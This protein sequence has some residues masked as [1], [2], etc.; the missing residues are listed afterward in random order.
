MVGLHY[1]GHAFSQMEVYLAKP[2]VPMSMLRSNS[3]MSP[4]ETQ[5]YV[6]QAQ[7]LY[8]IVLAIPKP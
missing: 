8:D 7:G 2:K 4:A 5:G 1:L 6:G 3:P